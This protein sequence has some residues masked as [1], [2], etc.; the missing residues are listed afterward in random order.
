METNPKPNLTAQQQATI[1]RIQARLA[2]L[3]AEATLTTQVSVGPVVTVYRMIPT[4]ST[5]VARLESL[6]D[7][8]SVAIANDVIVKRLPGEGCVGIYVPN[9]VRTDVFWRNIVGLAT[10]N[11]LQAKLE[12][13][14]GFGIDHLGRPYIEDLTLCPHLLIA[15]STGGGKSVFL[16]SLLATI[17]YTMSPSEISLFLSDTK[18]VEFT[19]LRNLPHLEDEIAND[20]EKTMEY[21]DRLASTVESRLRVFSKVGCANVQEYNRS[22]AGSNPFK[23]V[24]L[25]IDE[26][27]DIM[28][29]PGKGEVAK[30]G[31][32][33]LDL[34]VRRARAAGIHVIAATQ[35]PSV[36]VVAGVIKANFP[37]R[38][39]FRLPQGSDSMTV[40]GTVGAEHLLTRGD[41]LY[42]SPNKTG[43]VRLHAAYVSTEDIKA[44]IETVVMKERMAQ[45]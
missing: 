40:L 12:I 15:G 31:A 38:L 1:I 36:D 4:G 26:L 21:M 33:K 25:V 37:A 19:H 43:L 44:C 42:S 3:G 14:L 6:E 13:P 35:R 24:V 9:E 2:Q 27:A 20:A 16:K 11:K 5:T 10:N 18:C 28:L 39:T 7:D 41:M 22:H 17:A 32:K 29:L 45:R 30:R 23:Y 8:L 34:L